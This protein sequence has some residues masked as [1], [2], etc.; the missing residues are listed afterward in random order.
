VTHYSTPEGGPLLQ[1]YADRTINPRSYKV[2]DRDVGWIWTSGRDKGSV[3]VGGAQVI[4]HLK[5]SRRAG[6]LPG[7]GREFSL[8]DAAGNEVSHI[9]NQRRWFTTWNII[10]IHPGIS[11]PL[12][13]LLLAAVAAVDWWTM[14]KGAPAAGGG[15]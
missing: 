6:I 2:E 11:E 15:A 7:M 9:T 8:Y 14:P 10:E 4:G 5:R 12:R 1:V 3:C 13:T